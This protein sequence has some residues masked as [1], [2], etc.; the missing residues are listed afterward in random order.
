MLDFS[1]MSNSL[2]MNIVIYLL[3]EL[4]CQPIVSTNFDPVLQDIVPSAW[5]QYRDA[6]FLLVETY[7]A[8]NAH[9]FGEQF[10]DSIIDFVYSFP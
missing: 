7:L 5:L 2:L 9:A 8:H 4:L 1:L 10:N 3:N 6:V